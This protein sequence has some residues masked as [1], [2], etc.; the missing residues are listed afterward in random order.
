MPSMFLT[1]LTEGEGH[2]TSW[3]VSA[4]GSPNRGLLKERRKW[5]LLE[6]GAEEGVSVALFLLFDRIFKVPTSC[7]L[8]R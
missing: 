3:V 5:C 6:G 2:V 4:V 8:K 7:F 1:V